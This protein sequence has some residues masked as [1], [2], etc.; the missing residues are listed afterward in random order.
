M[1][2]LLF[3]ASSFTLRW[4]RGDPILGRNRINLAYLPEDT[5]LVHYIRVADAATSPTFKKS[6][7]GENDQSPF[8]FMERQ[9]SLRA[10]DVES[11][12]LAYRDKDAIA[13]Y[14]A[15]PGFSFNADVDW[16]GVARTKTAY[17][18]KAI[19][20]WLG[21]HDERTRAGET[22]HPYVDRLGLYFPDARTIVFGTRA[23]VEAAID[24]R[25]KEYRFEA[26][27]MLHETEH[28]SFVLDL[29][30]TGLE[31]FPGFK[32][33]R[34]AGAIAIGTTGR[35]DGRKEF[36]EKLDFET[37]TFAKV[38]MKAPG[39]AE[40]NVSREGSV[41]VQGE[42]PVCLAVGRSMTAWDLM[43]RTP[44]D[45]AHYAIR[46]IAGHERGRRDW[47]IESLLPPD[48]IPIHPRR[49]KEVIQLLSDRLEGPAITALAFLAGEEALPQIIDCLPREED[50]ERESAIAALR[51]L[52]DRAEP[53]LIKSL[54]S[55][56]VRIRNIC[57]GLLAE[58]ASEE[59]LATLSV[60]RQRERV[61]GH[62]IP[63]NTKAIHHVNVANLLP[64]VLPHDSRRRIS[65]A[66][67]RIGIE[68]SN[69]ES[70]TIAYP[71]SSAKLL[72]RANEWTMI[73]EREE[74]E[75]VAVI[76][77][78]RPIDETK[79]FR[80]LGETTPTSLAGVNCHRLGSSHVALVPNPR[81]IVAGTIA[82]MKLAIAREDTEPFELLDAVDSGDQA[83]FIFAD[84]PAGLNPSV[85]FANT[86]DVKS[87]ACAIRYT[88]GKPEH[89]ERLEFATHKEAWLQAAPVWLSGYYFSGD[90]SIDGTTA[91]YAD[92]RPNPTPAATAT[93]RL[94]RWLARGQ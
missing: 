85:F 68:L 32:D 46:V 70:V 9:T 38:R 14:K 6:V 79:A 16:L 77:F 23:E 81:T 66:E 83:T 78:R 48:A 22:W 2:I 40:D 54:D 62:F 29:D 10:E 87:Y 36:K 42:L 92:K 27:D 67:E 43:S 49:R 50:S 80:F 30:V 75:F 86:A 55:S 94:L 51:I 61:D 76:R 56:N 7:F 18:K 73:D 90:Y 93:F 82:E 69:V 88:D 24:R 39:L 21:A 45:R 4:W 58:C 47:A 44:F 63:A 28:F 91:I 13:A 8:E 52:G 5:K 12:L 59:R 25:G 53:G 11:V 84:R 34:N 35:Y 20:D 37:V 3:C 41:V 33:E 17:S 1:S 57:R 60:Q 26:F 64:H 89:T 15:S 74:L 72:G 31:E 71:E 65:R 19:R